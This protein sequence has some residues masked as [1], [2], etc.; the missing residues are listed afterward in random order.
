MKQINTQTLLDVGIALSKEKDDDKLLETILDAAMDITHCDAGTLYMLEADNLHFRV[1][2]TR[3]MNVR[4][5][6][7]NGAITLPAIPVRRPPVLPDGKVLQG[8]ATFDEQGLNRSNVCAI[9]AHQH[10]LINVRD[11]YESAEFDFSGPRRYDAMTGYRTASMLVVP[12]EDDRG[13]IIGVLQMMNAQDDAG[14]AIPFDVDF[15]PVILSLGSQAA[16]CLT[17]MSYAKEITELLDSFV[18][19]M[20]TAIDARSPYNANHTRNMV[21][22]GGRFLDW[23]SET[24]SDWTF[25]DEQRRQ[26]LMSVWLHDVGKL[27]IPLEVMDKQ[28]RLGDRYDDVMHRLTRFGLEN[29]VAFLENRLDEAAYTAMAGAIGDA[30]ALIETANTMGFLPDDTLAAIEAL[31]AAPGP[32][33]EAFLTSDE[34]TALSIR[35]GTLTGA[36]RAVIESHVVMTGKMLEEMKFSSGHKMV[37]RW[38]ASHHEFLN[39]K[40]Y[41]LGLAGDEIPREV[42]LLTILDVYDALTAVDRP[43]KPGLAP[44]K[45]FEILG[46]MVKDGQVDPDILNLFRESGAWQMSAESNT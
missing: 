2:I 6:G 23:L 45:A 16:I 20:S 41:P 44:E 42:R 28:T 33:G 37:P 10:R 46:F 26:F 22:Y 24:G 12:L 43:Y 11:V 30:R 8:G 14:R 19:V 13:D 29:R 5:G 25:N 9:C 40:G 4:Q 39:G 36:E 38:A 17:N 21:R 7:S 35:K 31:A 32:G 34:L 18:R 3:S 1:M 27:V 15:E